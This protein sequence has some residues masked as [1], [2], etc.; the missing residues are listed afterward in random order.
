[1][2]ETALLM[3][4]GTAVFLLFFVILGAARGLYKTLAGFFCV[5]ASIVGAAWVSASFSPAVTAYLYPS[6][7][8]KLVAALRA[9]GGSEAIASLL[10]SFGGDEAL[11][12]ALRENLG[13]IASDLVRTASESVLLVLV[14]GALLLLAFLALLL[15]LTLI[16]KA[17]GLVF[18]LPVLHTL[19]KF[20]GA[21]FGLAEGASLAF[22]AVHLSRSF[23]SDFLTSGAES[24]YLLSLFVDNTP[25]E[26]LA[27]ILEQKK[28]LW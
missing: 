14:Q 19:D 16:K 24:T 18:K 7:E 2:L 22:F 23:G 20:G 11:I 21:V 15:A 28:R 25:L 3:D 1:M 26:L 4:L 5:I 27:M 12:E 9:E 6:A 13:D 10:A 17:L 8:E